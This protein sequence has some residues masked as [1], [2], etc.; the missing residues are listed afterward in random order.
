MFLDPW[1]VFESFLA[2]SEPLSTWIP[3]PLVWLRKYALVI[4]SKDHFWDV[5]Q[6]PI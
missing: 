4:V 2:E 6:W 5:S 3:P 1:R